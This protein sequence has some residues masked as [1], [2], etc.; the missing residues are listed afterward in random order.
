MLPS[1]EAPPLWNPNAAANWS[2]L[3]SPVFGALLQMKNWEALGEDDKALNSK[4]RAIGAGVAIL[5]AVAVSIYSAISD[6]GPDITGSF[7][8]PLLIACMSCS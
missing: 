8:L 4:R 3:F 6:S 5:V 1:E 2:L 7:G